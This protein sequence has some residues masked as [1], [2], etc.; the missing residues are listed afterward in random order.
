MK[1]SL[2]IALL[3]GA[4]ALFWLTRSRAADFEPEPPYSEEGYPPM[5]V[6]D[7]QISPEGIAAIQ[8]RESFSATSYVDARGRSIGWGHFIQPG[9]S[10]AEPMDPVTAENLL[11]QDLANAQNAVRSYVT[12]PL[13]Q[14]QYDALVSFVYNI[15]GGAFRTSTLLA[16][17]NAGDYAGAAEQFARWNK[18]QG[19]ILTALINRR[20]SEA[21]QFKG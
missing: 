11:Y 12:V 9:E 2:L 15:G 5:D 16:K 3:F 19:S 18:S 6:R 20:A 17:L 21:E 1:R 14:N 10:F 8:D 13:S 7:M 4:G